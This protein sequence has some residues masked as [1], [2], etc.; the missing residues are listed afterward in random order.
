MESSVTEFIKDKLNKVGETEPNKVKKM[1]MKEFDITKD[2]FYEITR[3]YEMK[4]VG[5]IAYLEEFLSN[6]KYE[7][8]VEWEKKE[9]RGEFPEI[10]VAVSQ[11]MKKSYAMF[12]DMV[13]F[14]LVKELTKNIDSEGRKFNFGVF[15]LLDSNNRVLLGG[16]AFISIN[17][18]LAYAR[19]FDLFF[20]IQSKRPETV[21]TD[22]EPVFN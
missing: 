4:E 14:D 17:T 8:R 10:I 3:S 15:S 6:R 16:V 9:G 12:G 5:H 20:N 22:D 19:A 7:S 1:V 21:V 2:K 18:P 11:K 13:I